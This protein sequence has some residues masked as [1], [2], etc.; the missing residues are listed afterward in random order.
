MF[1]VKQLQNG[2]H[3]IIINGAIKQKRKFGGEAAA[4]AETGLCSARAGL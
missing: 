3:I 2:K 4:H 1:H